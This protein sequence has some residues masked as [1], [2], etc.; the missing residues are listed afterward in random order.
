M[1]V[2]VCVYKDES[3]K[4]TACRHILTD[5]QKRGTGGKMVIVLINRLSVANL[6]P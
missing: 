4:V 6:K 2:C 5:R 1:C 3:K